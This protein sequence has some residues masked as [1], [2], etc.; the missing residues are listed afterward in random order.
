MSVE[1]RSQSAD[2]ADEFVESEVS[3]GVVRSEMK[4]L[5]LSGPPVTVV[6]PGAQLRQMIQPP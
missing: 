4:R 3:R 2:E 1:M 5:R 6:G